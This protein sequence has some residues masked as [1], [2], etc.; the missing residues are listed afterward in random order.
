MVTMVVR[1]AAAKAKPIEVLRIMTITCDE[2][3]LPT[4][5]KPFSSTQASRQNQDGVAETSP[6]FRSPRQGCDARI[7]TNRFVGDLRQ[8]AN[9]FPGS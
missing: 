6:I 4:P 8:V 5:E 2:R 7:G 3:Y 1:Q 9:R